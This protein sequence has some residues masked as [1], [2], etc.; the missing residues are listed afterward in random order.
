MKDEAKCCVCCWFS[1]VLTSIILFG[2][3]FTTLD[4]NQLGLEFNSINRQYSKDKI[5]GPGRYMLGLGRQ[6]EAF[7][8]TWSQLRFCPGCPNGAAIAGRVGVGSSAVSVHVS[9]TVFYK[10]RGEY[11]PEVLLS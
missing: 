7:P 9:L 5:Y 3:S 2:C 6:L 10:L 4:V 1:V 11:I 8:T